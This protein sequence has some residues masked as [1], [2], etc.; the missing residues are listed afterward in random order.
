[1][2]SIK[3]K[4]K[5]EGETVEVKALIEHPM[6]TG[7]A[8]DK[9]TGELIPAHYITEVV[10]TSGDKTVMTANWGTAVS[11]NPYLSFSC[12]GKAGDKLKLSWKDNKGQSD[13][14]EADV[15]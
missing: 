1:M 10:V 7:Q 3:L 11:K 5:A 9:K 15:A 6:D 14:A 8:K 4:A 12:A 2:A 13:S